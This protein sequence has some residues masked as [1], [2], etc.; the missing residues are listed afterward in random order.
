MFVHDIAPYVC[1]DIRMSVELTTELYSEIL[2][3][4]LDRPTVKHVCEALDIDKDTVKGIRDK[5]IPALGLEPL[6]TAKIVRSGKGR[7]FTD[8][9]PTTP[10]EGE[11]AAAL[12]LI[13][14]E[15]IQR[16]IEAARSRLIRLST[17]S[18][19]LGE[20][21]DTREAAQQL[22][23]TT[24]VLSEA[25]AKL[26]IEKSR[27]DNIEKRAIASDNI[28]RSAEEAAVA[29]QQMRMCINL[30]AV[31]SYFIDA[32]M[33]AIEQGK[34]ELPKAFD[35]KMLGSLTGS[36]DRLTAA[37]ERAIKIER[38]RAGEPDNNLGIQIGVLI[39]TCTPEELSEIQVTGTLP[40]R[41]RSVAGGGDEDS[42]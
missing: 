20:A 3:A 9:A 18:L 10:I 36:L 42:E 5:G 28:R 35:P 14:H 15:E 39:N 41:L 21:V 1:Y 2:A 11:E 17:A 31:F 27:I 26:E 38:G 7:G 22:D 34:M 4:W 40:K 12:C 13:T 33:V 25:E 29:R 24:K 16:H 30:G 19:Q 6:P 32:T 8:A 23:G 37:T